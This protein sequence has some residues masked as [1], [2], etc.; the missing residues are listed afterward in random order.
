MQ[1][2][3]FRSRRR[4]LRMDINGRVRRPLRCAGN[5]GFAFDGIGLFDDGRTLYFPGGFFKVGKSFDALPTFL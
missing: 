3:L 1:I 2:R 4:F 5:F